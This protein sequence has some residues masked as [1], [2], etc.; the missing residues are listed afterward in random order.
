MANYEHWLQ[1]MNVT[2]YHNYIRM[3]E[4]FYL[5]FTTEVI[6]PNI[7]DI[8]WQN[9]IMK[10]FIKN[11]PPPTYDFF[12]NSTYEEFYKYFDVFFK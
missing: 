9:T 11:N 7:N 5:Y 8:A 6:I 10:R 3:L 4:K 2:D 12:I 1:P